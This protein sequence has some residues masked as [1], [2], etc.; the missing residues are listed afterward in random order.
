[1]DTPTVPRH[2]DAPPAMRCEECGN[3]GATLYMST[4]AAAFHEICSACREE[5]DPEGILA[6]PCLECMGDGLYD[7][8]TT[9]PECRGE[10]VAPWTL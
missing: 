4:V 6:E 3:A 5:F 9:C 1:M 2:T 10:G 7:D 8:S